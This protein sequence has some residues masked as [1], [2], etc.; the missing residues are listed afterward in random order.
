LGAT[1]RSCEDVTPSS[2]AATISVRNIST[3][4]G[5]VSTGLTDASTIPSEP[6]PA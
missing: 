6:P 4:I 1:R 2:M 3:Q 5:D